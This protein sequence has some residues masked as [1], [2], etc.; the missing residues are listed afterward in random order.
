MVGGRSAGRD[1]VQREKGWT[2]GGTMGKL[3]TLLG[4]QLVE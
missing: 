2:E 1:E 4:A 3:H